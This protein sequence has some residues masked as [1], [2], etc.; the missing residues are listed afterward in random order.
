MNIRPESEIS[1]PGYKVEG[2][3]LAPGD[4]LVTLEGVVWVTKSDSGADIVLGPGDILPA[5]KRAR[6]VIGGFRGR[7]VKVRVERAEH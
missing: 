5:E 2:V 3:D 4:S 7:P 6:A 1:V